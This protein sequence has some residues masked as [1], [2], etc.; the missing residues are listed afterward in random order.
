MT[1]QQNGKEPSG[2]IRSTLEAAIAMNIQ[3][4]KTICFI[5]GG[6][7]KSVCVI[8]DSQFHSQSPSNLPVTKTPPLDDL[9]ASHRH[10]RPKQFSLV[11]DALEFHRIPFDDE[12]AHVDGGAVV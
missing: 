8:H 4:S 2:R 1:D 6:G 5:S 7:E 9:S 10:I 3:L 11:S 12:V